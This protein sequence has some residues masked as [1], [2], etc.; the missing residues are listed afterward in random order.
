[1][2]EL[3]DLLMKLNDARKDEDDDDKSNESALQRFLRS[4]DDREVVPQ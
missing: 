4:G 2:K 3:V 1:M